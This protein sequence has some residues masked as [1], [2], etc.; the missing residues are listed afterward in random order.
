VSVIYVRSLLLTIPR[1]LL[2]LLR[3]YGCGLV[4]VGGRKRKKAG[5][6]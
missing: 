6:K 2:T 1:D 3:R 5:L 4:D